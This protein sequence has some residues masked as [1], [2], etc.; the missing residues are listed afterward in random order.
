[1]SENMKK[2]IVV[3]LITICMFSIGTQKSKSAEISQSKNHVSYLLD[4]VEYQLF[5]TVEIVGEIKSGD[6]EKFLNVLSLYKTHNDFYKPRPSDDELKKLI[7]IV[8]MSPK[9][10]ILQVELNSKGGDVLEAMKIGRVI[11]RLRLSTS[12]KTTGDPE[13]SCLSA[14]FFIFVAG[15]KRNTNLI[16][17]RDLGVH[18]PYFQPAYFA[19]LTSTQAKEKYNDLVRLT[20]QYLRDMYVP[21]ELIELSYSISPDDIYPLSEKE[22][23][24]W[25][26]EYH[27]FFEDWLSSKCAHIEKPFPEEIKLFGKLSTLSEDYRNYI[28]HKVRAPHQCMN[29]AFQTEQLRLLNQ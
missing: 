2:S 27:P 10:H 5:S 20:K 8:F 7:N 23:E 14:C 18:R 13:E 17:D 3:V 21:E 6:Y 29:H 19:G 25:L 9:E 26:Y 15:V 1:M 16:W 12:L 11:E 24:M 4:E 22:I 28:Y